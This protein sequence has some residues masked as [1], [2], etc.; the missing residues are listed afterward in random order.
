MKKTRLLWLAALLATVGFS[1]CKHEEIVFDNELPQF[2]LRND[3][4]L[5]EVISPQETGRKDVLYIAGDFNGG[6]ENAL[7]NEKWKLTQS[8]D[9]PGNYGIY[10][11]P[12]DFVGGKTLADG[13]HFINRR[14]GVEKSLKG[15]T[16]V[17]YDNPQVGTR[18]QVRVDHWASFFE[19]IPHNGYVLYVLNDAGWTEINLYAWADGQP[20]LFGAWPGVEATGKETIGELEF[21]YFDLGAD[22]EDKTYNLIVNNGGNGEGNEL[23]I[24][25]GFTINRNLYIHLI[26]ATTSEEIDREGNPYEG[27][28][29]EGNSP[30]HPL[31]EGDEGGYRIYVDNQSSWRQ[32]GL[33]AWTGSGDLFGGWPGLKSAGK[34]KIGD[35]NFVYFD[36]GKSTTGKTIN[37]II[38]NGNGGNGNQ[39]GGPTYTVDHDIYLRITSDMKSQSDNAIEID[40]DGKVISGGDTEPVDPDA[41][42]YKIYITDNTGWANVYLYTYKDA[43]PFN[44]GAWPGKK[45]E[46]T[47]TIDGVD[48]KYVVVKGKGEVCYTI[49]NNNDKLQFD[50]PQ[51][52]MDKDYFFNVT[53]TQCTIIK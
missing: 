6:D 26:D 24:K 17:R 23:A 50:G 39:V 35:I 19:G 14:C 10:L 20:E 45:F 25:S 13:Y 48:Y 41:I 52:T 21:Y 40:K 15:D 11:N 36:L 3:A 34:E 31:A 22:N 32:L 5:I 16:V 2:E 8:E 7:K 43:Q 33:H 42:D 1:G 37:T 4:I 27:G 28:D 12:A 30:F 47:E 51:I 44:T 9:M 18:L 49:F 38:N 29:D 53:A 46:Q